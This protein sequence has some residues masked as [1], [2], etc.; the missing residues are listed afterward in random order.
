MSRL[1]ERILWAVDVLD[2]RP[3]DIILEIGCGTGL[4]IGPVCDRLSEGNLIAIDRSSAQLEKAK[5]ANA[6]SIASGKAE[7]LLTEFLEAKLPPAHFDK[8]FLFNINVF[9]MDP[10]AELA[11]IKR[12]LKPEGNFYLFHQPPPGNDVREFAEAFRANLEKYGFRI[13]ETS[14]QALKSVDA[15]CLISAPL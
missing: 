13:L 10:K 15:L 5:A 7:I 3:A 1:P 4:A 6:D 9:W 12:L 8:I 14:F 2:V 11:E